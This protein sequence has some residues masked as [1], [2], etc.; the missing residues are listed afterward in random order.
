MKPPDVFRVIIA[1]LEALPAEYFVSGSVAS[2]HWGRP[3]FTQDMDVLVALSPAHAPRLSKVFPD[4]EFHLDES[5]VAYAAEHGGQCNLIHVS[6]G[7]KVD[8][9]QLRDEPFSESRMDRRRRRE[10]FPGVEAWIASPEDV[11]LSKLRY[12]VSG[13]SHKHINDSAAILDIRGP[14]LDRAYIERWASKLGVAAAW[15]ELLER[16]QPED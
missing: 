16:P 3:R 8:I 10:L 15:H 4:P 6:T 7:Y 11:I 1:A 13:G 12:Y 2:S 14:E 9:I 5:A